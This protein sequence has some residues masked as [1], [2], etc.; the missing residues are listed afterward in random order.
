[1]PNVILHSG[2][3]VP[4]NDVTKL[5]MPYY[6]CVVVTLSP[7]CQIFLGITPPF[8]L[9]ISTVIVSRSTLFDAI[10]VWFLEY[11]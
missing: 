2:S 3:L 1:M 8:W 6:A 11:S 10:V 4:L 5:N 9:K 7:H